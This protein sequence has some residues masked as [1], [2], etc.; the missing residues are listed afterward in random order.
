MLRTLWKD[1]SGAIITAE[2]CLVLTIA[3]LATIVGLSE[4]AVAINT[5]LNDV[6]NAIGSLNQSFVFTGFKSF[7]RHKTKSFVF[8]SRFHD[9]I[10]DCD[11]NESCEI[12][13]GTCNV[14]NCSEGLCGNDHR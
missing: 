9:Q 2:L 12:V 5:E 6:S 8:G 1:E 11:K 3:V 4:C 14:G 10:D 13:C 7:D